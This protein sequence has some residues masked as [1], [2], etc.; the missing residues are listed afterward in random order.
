VDFRPKT[1]QCRFSS[2]RATSKAPQES[3]DAFK[4]R[5]LQRGQLEA[6]A[7]MSDATSVQVTQDALI[8]S[9]L[10]P[11][12][13]GACADLNDDAPSEGPVATLISS[14]FPL[15]NVHAA[16]ILHIGNDALGGL[17]GQQALTTPGELISACLTRVVGHATRIRHPHIRHR[18]SMW[19]FRIWCVRVRCITAD[20]HR[21]RVEM[22]AAVALSQLKDR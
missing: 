5:V 16:P 6:Q 21:V 10:A 19:V 3:G 4:S 8:V 13:D 14:L 20:R 18:T 9:E 15:H 2:P 1:H 17:S 11:A 7:D 12:T 22:N